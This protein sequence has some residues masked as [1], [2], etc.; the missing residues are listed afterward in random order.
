MAYD[1]T[2]TGYSKEGEEIFSL[3]APWWDGFR[4]MGDKRF[5][6]F[7]VNPGYLDCL[8][9]LSVEETKALNDEYD[10]DVLSYYK[11]AYSE[12]MKFLDDA[13]NVYGEKVY[14]KFHIHIA[15]W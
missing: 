11:K 13:I 5:K 15:E 9:S 8:A 7:E 4:L 2:I 12:E 6:S 1:V 14:S 3:G 10:S